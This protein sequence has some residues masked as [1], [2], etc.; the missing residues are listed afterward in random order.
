MPFGISHGRARCLTELPRGALL[1]GRNAQ[2]QHGPP[3][4]S[5]LGN[6][7]S[8]F[9]RGK[10]LMFGGPAELCRDMRRID[11][12]RL[13][14]RECALTSAKRPRPAG[15]HYCPKY[16]FHMF[17]MVSADKNGA[18]NWE[19]KTS[20]FIENLYFLIFLDHDPTKT[21]HFPS[22]FL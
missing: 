15:K 8:T 13:A 9:R 4:C 5:P 7:K 14:H 19:P 10:T 1:L 21:I 6:R 3:Y 22:L 11:A 12:T 20:L 17:S 2:L 18:L 16:N